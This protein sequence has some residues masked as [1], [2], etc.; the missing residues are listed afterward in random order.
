MSSKIPIQKH[1][2]I[3]YVLHPDIKDP[4][5]IEGILLFPFCNLGITSWGHET[6][7]VECD[8]CQQL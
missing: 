5:R 7:S 2:S 8:S 3:G 1:S 6:K 4:F